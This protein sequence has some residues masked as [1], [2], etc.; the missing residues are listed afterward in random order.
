MLGVR[1]LI[2]IGFQFDRVGKKYFYGYTLNEANDVRIKR[3]YI[4]TYASRQTSASHKA[5]DV[6]AEQYFFDQG[7][8]EANRCTGTVLLRAENPIQKREIGL[9]LEG[10]KARRKKDRKRKSSRLRAFA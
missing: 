6:A 3:D 10:V 2:W 5:N 9:A 7:N 1:G 4:N 8:Y